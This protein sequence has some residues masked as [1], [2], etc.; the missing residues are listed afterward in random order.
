VALLETDLL[1]G[2]LQ[3]DLYADMARAL[4]QR[5]RERSL[6]QEHAAVL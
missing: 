6:P 3:S 2:F 4:E 5:R 1:P